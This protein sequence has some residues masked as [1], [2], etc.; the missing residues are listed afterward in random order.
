MSLPLEITS[1]TIIG[2]IILMLAISLFIIFSIIGEH[3]QDEP[4][5]LFLM[6]PALFVMSIF[7]FW[8]YNI[9]IAGIGGVVSLLLIVFSWWTLFTPAVVVSSKDYVGLPG[10]A[11]EDLDRHIPREIKVYLR[12]GNEVVLNAI[13]DPEQTNRIKIPARSTIY[14]SSFDGVIAKVAPNIPV[15]LN[16]SNNK[17]LPNPFSNLQKRIKN[18]FMNATKIGNCAICKLPI[19]KYQDYL[20][21]PCCKAL[22]HKEHILEWLK[23]KGTCPHCKTRIKWNGNKLLLI[24][25]DV[26]VP[27]SPDN[28]KKE[29]NN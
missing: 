4:P 24:N 15:I 19:T 8:G 2:I 5:I 29:K 18:K 17:G 7:L 21:L 26:I 11:L 22:A 25:E 28:I 3:H 13:I 9:L 20:K 14:I 6:S 12:N 27:L 23:I 10:I 16:S 1:N